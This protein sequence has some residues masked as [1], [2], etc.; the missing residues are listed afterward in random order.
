MTSS[1]QLEA[2]TASADTQSKSNLCTQTD[3]VFAADG[4][5]ARA[6][7]NYRPRQ[8]Q[9]DM[10]LAVAEAIDGA[11]TLVVEAGTGTGKTFAYLVPALLSNQRVLIS[12]ATKTLQDQLYTRDLPQVLAAL[13]LL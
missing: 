2:A 4:V 9:K 13:A 12:T 8:A 3:R 10:A 7:A 1:A 6:S 11:S 5:L